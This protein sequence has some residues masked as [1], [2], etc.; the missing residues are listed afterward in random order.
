MFYTVGEMAK[1]LGIAP[2][3]LRYYD[4]EG[5]LPF[6]ERSGSGIRMFKDSDMEWM[7]IIECLKKTGMPIKEIKMFIDWCMEGDATI[8]K[9]LELIDNQRKNVLE[10]TEQLKKTLDTLNFKHWYYETAK[11]AGTCD[12]HKKRSIRPARLEDL[13]KI[14]EIYK[15]ARDFM[16]K[17]GNESQWGNSYPEKEMLSDDID[18]EQLYVIEE[19]NRICGV[20]AFIIG[21]DET[22]SKI[23]GKWMEDSEYGTIHR[24]AG[25]GITHGIMYTAVGY[26]KKIISHLRID[27]H[28][29]NHIMKSLIERCGFEKCGTIYTYDGSPRI[30]YEML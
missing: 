16:A 7:L 23:D 24:I 19:K 3:A 15:N 26:C 28:E 13:E 12:I 14:E 10:Q 4:K 27:T 5:L 11:K 9:R 29:N 17:S 8:D 21:E 2:S 6:V 22:Y 1:K 25:D 30:A 18:K 20:F